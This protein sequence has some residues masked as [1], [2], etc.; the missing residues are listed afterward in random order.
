MFYYGLF[1]GMELL[2]LVIKFYHVHGLS[3]MTFLNETFGLLVL[4]IIESVR[5]YIGQ[6]ENLPKKMSAVFRILILTVPS[7][8][9]VAYFTF[10]QVKITRL[11]VILGIIM[12]VVQ[13]IQLVCAFLAWLPNRRR[14]SYNPLET[15]F[16]KL[17]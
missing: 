9:G 17:D 5:L 12:L 3:T 15:N 4:S 13:S 8:Y 14:I 10:W 2:F 11:D 7:M 6:E 16:D 1:A